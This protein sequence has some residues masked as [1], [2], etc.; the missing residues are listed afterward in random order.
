MIWGPAKL[1]SHCSHFT[2]SQTTDHLPVA[3]VVRPALAIE[4]DAA[5]FDAQEV[6]HGR[7]QIGRRHGAIRDKRG[8]VVGGGVHD[9]LA[10]SRRAVDVRGERLQSLEEI[11]AL[12][13][14]GLAIVEPQRLALN[15][16]CGFAPDAGEPPTIDEAYEKLCRLASAARRLRDGCSS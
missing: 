7:W 9:H 11:E 4:N 14:A 5:G 2:L 13:A 8:L 6:K 1:R 3:R 15:P 16:D 12:A 10:H